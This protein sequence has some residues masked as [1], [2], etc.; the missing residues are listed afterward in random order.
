MVE[1]PRP[2]G[3]RQ[4][5]R[6]GEKPRAA[7]AGVE[8]GGYRGSRCVPRQSGLRPHDRRGLAHGRR[9]ASRL[10][11]IGWSSP[12]RR[13][14]IAPVVVIFADTSLAH[15]HLASAAEYGSPRSWGRRWR[16]HSTT[17]STWPGSTVSPLSI[18]IFDTVPPLTATIGLKVFIAS[19]S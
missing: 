16:V 12:R 8:A 3:H 4:A 9:H 6:A 2:G 5:A 7:E 11:L 18:R 1:R 13:G 14:P 10:R 19:I 17:I 15:R